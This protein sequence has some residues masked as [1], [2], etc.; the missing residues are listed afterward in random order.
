MCREGALSSPNNQKINM[1]RGPGKYDDL[2]T[3][4]RE[5]THAD[6]VILMII[7]GEQGEGFSLQATPQ[8]LFAAPR[9]LRILADQLEADLYEQTK[10]PKN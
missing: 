10:V 4:C 5:K 8:V 3:Y 9:A 7:G 2:A 1:L 6:G